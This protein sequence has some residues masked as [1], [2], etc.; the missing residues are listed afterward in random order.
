MMTR[1][2][3][4]IFKPKVY[5]GKSEWNETNEEPNSVAEALKHTGW[6]QAMENEL[7]AL[8]R[9]RTWTLVPKKSGMNIIGNKWV[10]KVKKN[11]DGSVERLKARL[12]AKGFIQRL[13]IDFGSGESFHN[14]YYPYN[15]CIKGMGYS[16]TRY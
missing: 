2:K 6:S 11:S 12:V 8:E 9:N 4:G 15:C 7:A 10:F 3:S 16:T 13:G 14:S 1:A 5:L